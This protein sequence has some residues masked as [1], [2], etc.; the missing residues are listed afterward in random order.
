MQKELFPI[1]DCV[2]VQLKITEGGKKRNKKKISFSAQIEVK[3]R[4]WSC[5]MIDPASF[6][7]SSFLYV[8]R[9]KWWR[10]EMWI[11]WDGWW[12]DDD[13]DFSFFSG[14]RMMILKRLYIPSVMCCVKMGSVLVSLFFGRLLF[15]FFFRGTFEHKSRLSLNIRHFLKPHHW[16]RSVQSLT[17]LISLRCIYFFLALLQLKLCFISQEIP[18]LKKIRQQRATNTSSST[19]LRLSHIVPSSRKQHFSGRPPHKN[20]LSRLSGNHRVTPTPKLCQRRGSRIFSFVHSQTVFCCGCEWDK[21]S[22]S[23]GQM[24]SPEK[25]IVLQEARILSYK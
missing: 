22:R 9:W 20:Q 13:I 25:K 24:T 14:P 5:S 2:L 19:R 6:S 16:M 11:L 7:L 15:I 4:V 21:G 8:T 23:G 18:G 1:I 12:C 10:R 17:K 3:Y